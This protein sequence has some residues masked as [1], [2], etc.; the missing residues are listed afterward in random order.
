MTITLSL[1][2]SKSSPHNNNYTIIKKKLQAQ[3]VILF[4]SYAIY[5]NNKQFPDGF[6]PHILRLIS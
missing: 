2:N 5:F 4:N 6:A 1:S 3:P